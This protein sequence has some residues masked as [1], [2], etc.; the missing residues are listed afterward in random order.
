[1]PQISAAYMS[2]TRVSSFENG[3]NEKITSSKELS[4][5]TT[6]CD[7]W[8]PFCKPTKPKEKCFVP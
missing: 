4:S 6:H 7:C 1:M 3:K 5:T 8:P 2:M